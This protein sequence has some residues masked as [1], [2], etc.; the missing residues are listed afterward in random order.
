MGAEAVPEQEGPCVWGGLRVR[1]LRGCSGVTSIEPE[2]CFS[3]AVQLGSLT[4]GLPEH[5][6]AIFSFSPSATRWRNE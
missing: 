4:G 1:A 3:L 6:R 5:S 2:Q